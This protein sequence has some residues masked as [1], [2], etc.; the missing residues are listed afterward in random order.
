M[1]IH[2]VARQLDGTLTNSSRRALNLLLADPEEMS[3][4]SATEVAGRI[5][6]H[7][8]TVIRLARQLGY[9][10][11]RELRAELASAAGQGTALTSAERVRS[12][13]TYTLESLVDDEVGAMSRLARLVRQD[14][15]DELAQRILDARRLMLFG[16]P[17]AGA[18][19]NVLERRVRRFG[20]Q[21]VA[22]P[23]S[24]RL[25]A[26][27][28]T[29]LSDGDMVLSFVFRRPDSRVD[30]INSF[31]TDKGAITAV[32]ADEGGYTYRP[33]PDQLLVAPRGPNPNQRSLM[34]PFLICYAIQNALHH[35]APERVEKA[36]LLLDDI[37]KVVGDDE[38]SHGQ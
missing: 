1:G 28:L 4:L 3:Q 2:E 19:L 20:V 24:G 36:L 30:R 14:E 6:V 12:R 8:A 10:G 25:I 33:T 11:Y 31:A 29:T 32:I 38:P 37:A 5:G 17:Y 7:E 16:P 23:T 18:V 21:S 9:S 26:E 15:V 35:L 27:H 34:V 13:A 22:L